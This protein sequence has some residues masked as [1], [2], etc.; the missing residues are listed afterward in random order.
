MPANQEATH[1]QNKHSIDENIETN[2][3]TA[4]N[5]KIAFEGI[6]GQLGDKI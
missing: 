4:K 6:Q 5:D 1:V 3:C 2:V